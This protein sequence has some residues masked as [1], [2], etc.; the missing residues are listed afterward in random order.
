MGWRQAHGRPPLF[1]RGKYTCAEWD[2]SRF[3]AALVSSGREYSCIGRQ[4]WRE[5]CAFS[6]GPVRHVARVTL[7]EIQ[8]SLLL[9]PSETL[10]PHVVRFHL[11]S[12]FPFQELDQV[13]LASHRGRSAAVHRALSSFTARWFLGHTLRMARSSVHSLAG[14]SGGRILRWRRPCVPWPDLSV[15]RHARVLL[16]HGLGG[17]L[18][19][20]AHIVG[21]WRTLAR[22]RRFGPQGGTAAVGS[23]RGGSHRLVARHG[24]RL[25][26]QRPSSARRAARSSALRAARSSAGPCF[27][28]GPAFPSE[29]GFGFC[30][31]TVMVLP[32]PAGRG[33]W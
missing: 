28:S 2:R 12:T 25:V 18:L 33:P 15:H 13:A 14:K 9:P 3:S 22:R 7:S 6:C 26:A 27:S 16:E 31:T 32:G 20:R 5:R 23:P 19:R 10:I 17:A 1:S 4:R 21:K 29:A 30:G 8:Q 11:L 24:H